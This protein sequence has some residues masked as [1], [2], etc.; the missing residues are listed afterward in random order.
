VA[1]PAIDPTTRPIIPTDPNAIN[2]ISDPE[3]VDASKWRLVGAEFAELS[4]GKGK[5]LVFDSVNDLAQTDAFEVTEGE[6]LQV[7]LY[8]QSESHPPPVF[9]AF[10]RLFDDEGYISQAIGS[11]QGTSKAGEWQEVVDWIRIDDGDPERTATKAMLKLSLIAQPVAAE[12]PFVDC[13]YKSECPECIAPKIWIDDIFAGT[14][15]GFEQATTKSGYDSARV[16]VDPL[17][18]WSICPTPPCKDYEPFFPIIVYPRKGTQ[19]SWTDWSTYKAHGF[20]AVT[21][22]MTLERAQKATDAGLMVVFELGRAFK[23]TDDRWYGNTC[24]VEER[25]GSI[26]DAGL[27]PNVLTY[28]VDNEYVTTCADPGNCPAGPQSIMDIGNVHKVVNTIRALDDAPLHTLNVNGGIPRIYNGLYDTTGTYVHFDVGKPGGLQN[29]LAE[30]WVVVDRLQ[31][32]TQP[33]TIASINPRYLGEPSG[34][35]R[36]SAAGFRAAVYKA[37]IMGARGFSVHVD[38]RLWDPRELC[39]EECAD[40]VPQDLCFKEGCGLECDQNGFP[41]FECVEWYEELPVIASEI[42]RMEGLLRAPHWITWKLEVDDPGNTVLW[43]TRTYEG[44]GFV[45]MVNLGYESTS[46]VLAPEGGKAKTLRNYLTDK[47]VAKASKGK[48]SLVLKP[49]ET[50]VL[51][52]E[53]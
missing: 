30:R 44:K 18:N 13:S 39:P 41:P 28:Y 53:P 3:I 5:S 50:T 10:F 16:R 34:F 29:G 25:L 1:C 23:D 43:G 46:I 7:R 14:D 52:F 6:L 15:L 27:L 11:F 37:L 12:N 33:A 45:L 40:W 42:D 36:A 51:R 21:G 35:G 38:F 9:K 22:W 8:L 49:M 4:R 26:I 32:Q 24:D 2:R 48:F 17:G 19:D 31:G 20:N 47:I